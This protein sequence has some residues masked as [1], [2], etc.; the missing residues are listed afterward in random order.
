[1]RAVSSLLCEETWAL[2]NWCF[3]F[4]LMFLNYGVG[5]DCWE[6]LG[7]QG[8]PTH[9]SYRWVL[10][11]HWNDWCWS[12]NANILATWCEELTH[13]KTPSCWRVWGRRRRGRQRM[14]WLDSIINLMDVCLGK[15]QELVMDMEAWCAVIHGFTK[16]QT[17]LSDWTELIHSDITVYY[18]ILNFS[19]SCLLRSPMI[20]L[21]LTATLKFL[22]KLLN[23]PQLQHSLAYVFLQVYCCLSEYCVS[24]GNF[25]ALSRQECWS[26][27][28]F[29]SPVDHVLSEL[30][31]MT[32]LGWPCKLW[33]ILSLS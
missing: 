1:M 12:W 8:D 7:L 32:C 25:T 20:P 31:T 24:A 23:L 16:S 22:S 33:F 15:L 17:G 11:V 6:S 3:F 18:V 27:L 2:K 13:W 14:R 9:P 5:E 30:S 4:L 10:C 21:L 26:G 28:P 19:W 29:L